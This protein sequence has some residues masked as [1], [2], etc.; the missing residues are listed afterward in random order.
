MLDAADLPDDIASVKA[1]L[2]VAQAREVRKDD[3]EQFDLA[4]EYLETAVHADDEADSLSG[5]P[6]PKSRVANRGSLPAHLPRVE[7]TIEP[8]SLIYNSGG[9]LHCIGEDASNGWSH[10]GT[11]PCHRHP[12][13]KI[14]LLCLHRRFVSGSSTR[15]ADS[16]RITDR[17]GYNTCVGGEVRQ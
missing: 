12:P 14:C 8:E 11:I 7:E 1:M 5:K 13:S 10:P 16:G 17:S 3:P 4:L 6:C 2:V 9:G 15:S